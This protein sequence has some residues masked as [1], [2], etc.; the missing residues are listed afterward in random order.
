MSGVVHRSNSQFWEQLCEC[1]LH[2][3]GLPFSHLSASFI[4]NQNHLAVEVTSISI[5]QSR[6]G[7]Q[8]LSHTLQMTPL[9]CERL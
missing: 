2:L 3:C 4:I 7:P 5:C 6:K 1:Y 8:P 9:C